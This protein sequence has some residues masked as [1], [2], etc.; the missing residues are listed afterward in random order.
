MSGST[1]VRNSV[2]ESEVKLFS[3]VTDR[4]VEVEGSEAVEVIRGEEDDV[5]KDASKKSTNMRM[6][7]LL[8]PDLRHLGIITAT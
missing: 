8:E 4:E 2:M 7:C 6:K 3:E 5:S 1:K